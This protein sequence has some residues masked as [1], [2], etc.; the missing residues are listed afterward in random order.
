MG[1]GIL[2]SDDIIV[3]RKFRWV[4]AL[5]L[6]NV[7]SRKSDTAFVLPHR[8][9][10][11]P[12]LT[13][14]EYEF[15]HL[16]ETIFYPLKPSW[17][18]IDMTLYDI[19]DG[20]NTCNAVFDWVRLATSPLDANGVPP[21]GIYDPQNGTF[22]PVIP[23]QFKRTTD[24]FIYDGNGKTLEHWVMD[25]CYPSRIRWGELDMDSSDVLTVDI[26]LRYDRAYCS[27]KQPVQNPPLPVPSLSPFVGTKVGNA[28]PPSVGNPFFGK[29]GLP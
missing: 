9:G 7:A 4:M 23:A 19:C 2:G 3:K 27:S 29:I 26:S 14:K 16:N 6:R 21:P 20:T 10:S 28:V 15:Q 8:R 25:N 1:L 17:E 18:P 5:R 12:N 11:R 13:W 24:L 22:R